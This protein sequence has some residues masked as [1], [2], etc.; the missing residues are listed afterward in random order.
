MMDQFVIVMVMTTINVMVINSTT[1]EMNL[2]KQ[3]GVPDHPFTDH[4]DWGTLLRHVAV[5]PPPSNYCYTSS[6]CK[7]SYWVRLAA[8]GGAMV[9]MEDAL[10]SWMC[11]LPLWWTVIPLSGEEW[12]CVCRGVDGV[13]MS[14]LLPGPGP[15]GGTPEP[16]AP[17]LLWGCWGC[18]IEPR[19]WSTWSIL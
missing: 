17:V 8:L 13:W 6:S 12:W 4:F 7:W 10:V 14:A 16:D 2:I 1:I 11:L 9:G 3:H 18:T 19:K 15:G 5:T